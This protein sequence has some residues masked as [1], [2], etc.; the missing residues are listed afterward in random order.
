MAEVLPINRTT[1]KAMGI[2]Q[3]LVN[4]IAYEVVGCAIE[5]YK[6]DLLGID[7]H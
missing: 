6:H 5:V 4:Q 1:E 7:L 2:T 3:K